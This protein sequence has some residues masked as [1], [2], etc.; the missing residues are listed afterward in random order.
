MT[1]TNNPQETPQ[2]KQGCREC[3]EVELHKLGCS[4]NQPSG[5][6]AIG[7]RLRSPVL[8]SEREVES[9]SEGVILLVNQKQFPSRLGVHFDAELDVNFCCGL[10][11]DDCRD[12]DVPHVEYIRADLVTEKP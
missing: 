3:K 12:V 7:A 10:Q 8:D 11:L 1:P 9:Q 2:P 6:F 5:G 4:L